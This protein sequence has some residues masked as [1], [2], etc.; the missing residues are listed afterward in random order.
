VSISPAI[1]EIAQYPFASRVS[2]VFRRTGSF[3]RISRESEPSAGKNQTGAIRTAA[4]DAFECR[5]RRLES[6]AAINKWVRSAKI[7]PR[8]ARQILP[9][10]GYNM[11]P[12]KW[13][14]YTSCSNQP[15]VANRRKALRD[16]GF[17]RS[18]GLV[19]APLRN[20]ASTADQLGRFRP[21]CLIATIRS[22]FP[23]EGGS[24]GKR[25]PR[26]RPPP[27]TSRAVR[28]GQRR[29]WPRP[30]GNGFHRTGQSAPPAKPRPRPII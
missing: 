3:L 6:R 7:A 24:L 20:P 16:P 12:K 14:R 10:L 18:K 2:A 28:F 26:S 13:C 8:G 19:A 23:E 29:C 27:S 11:A 9:S 25:S 5:W 30:S 4:S 22:P 17:R 21:Q 15:D 1:S